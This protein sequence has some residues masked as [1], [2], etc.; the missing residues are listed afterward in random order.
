MLLLFVGTFLQP[1]FDLFPSVNCF[2]SKLQSIWIFKFPE[3]QK[4]AP[5][6]AYILINKKIMLWQME[7]QYSFPNIQSEKAGNTHESGMAWLREGLRAG[8]SST[9][10]EMTLQIKNSG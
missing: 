8:L 5:C 3:D 10:M 7:W 2:I 9:E 1:F 4:H 6:A